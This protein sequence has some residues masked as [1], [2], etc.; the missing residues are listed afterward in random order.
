[1]LIRNERRGAVPPVRQTETGFRWRIG[2]DAVLGSLKS[3]PAF[4]R[5]LRRAIWLRQC[6]IRGRQ[7][8]ED[9]L[10]GSL[11]SA[12]NAITSLIRAS[13]KKHTLGFVDASNGSG[14]G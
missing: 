12:P 4:A 8:P 10:I 9:S 13:Y 7:Q 5:S 2:L 3:R 11:I 1:M 6:R 14:A